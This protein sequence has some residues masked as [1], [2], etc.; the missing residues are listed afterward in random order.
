MWRV[1][2]YARHP[3]GPQ[4]VADVEI[5]IPPAADVV[6]FWGSRV[7]APDSAGQYLEAM[8]VTSLTPSAGLPR[9]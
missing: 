5:H 9:A 3:S 7:F 1:R 8:P 2:L 4:F 6:V